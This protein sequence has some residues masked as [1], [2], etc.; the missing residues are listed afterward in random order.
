MSRRFF[1]DEENSE[2]AAE[3]SGRVT[4]DDRGNA[5][6]AAGRRKRTSQPVL[7]LAEEVVPAAGPVKHN[8]TGLKS[9]YDPY[10]SGLLKGG[11]KEAFRK[12]K[13][14]AALSKWIQL[15]KN[16]GSGSAE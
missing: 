12:K 16:I 1:D 2:T 3:R 14:L 4:F 13:N 5:V 11:K 7:S 6:W 9:G 8:R 15:K 10:E